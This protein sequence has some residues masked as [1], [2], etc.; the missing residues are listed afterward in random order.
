[1]PSPISVGKYRAFKELARPRSFDFLRYGTDAGSLAY[2]DTGGLYSVD[3]DGPG[4][5]PAFAFNQP[6][7]NFKSVRVNAIFRWEWRPGSTLYVAWTQKREDTADPGVFEF[8]HDLHGLF[9]APADDV[10]LVKAS[11]RFGR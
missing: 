11:Y 10:L 1:M 9:S 5:A 4:P 2:D 3:P 6:N 7:F 8:R